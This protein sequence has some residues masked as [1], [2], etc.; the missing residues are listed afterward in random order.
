[1]LHK[2][3]NRIR[4]VISHFDPSLRYADAEELKEYARTLELESFKSM[5]S[6][7]DKPTVFSIRPLQV[8]YE[9]MAYGSGF[10]DT[11]RIFA[12]HV[13]DI[14]GLDFEI[15]R[16]GVTSEIDD[17][18]KEDF[19]PDVVQNISGIIIQLANKADDKVF[20]T[21]P[22][23]F[24]DYMVSLKTRLAVES[25]KSNALSKKKGVKAKR[26]HTVKNK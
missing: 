19:I 9:Y 7:P 24:W 18:H 14:E 25:M 26:S 5:D 1:M 4:K 8:K 23:G 3:I 22:E 16:N 6:W 10:I 17:L 20:F 2:R 12:T 15:Q 11:W 13:T 21:P